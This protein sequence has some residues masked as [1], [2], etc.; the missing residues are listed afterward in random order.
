MPIRKYSTK[1]GTSDLRPRSWERIDPVLHRCSSTKLPG[2]I[3]KKDRNLVMVFYI[4]RQ[5]MSLDV[6]I[7]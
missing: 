4:E 5:T 6:L 3:L 7:I 2:F 1:E